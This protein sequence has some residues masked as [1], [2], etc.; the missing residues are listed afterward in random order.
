MNRNEKTPDSAHRRSRIRCRCLVR[1]VKLEN[2]MPRK[3]YNPPPEQREWEPATKVCSQCNLERPI[4]QFYVNH[5]IKR[6]TG[7]KKATYNGRPTGC[8]GRSK[9]CIYCH[10]EVAKTHHRRKLLTSM[11]EED[12]VFHIEDL[13]K[14]LQLAEEIL[15]TK[16]AGPTSNEGSQSGE[17]G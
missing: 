4:N 2:E 5:L 16:K 1:L 14:H 10:S 7:Y 13:Q 12:L 3:R 8:P 15:K 11:T 17:S 6:V 9:I